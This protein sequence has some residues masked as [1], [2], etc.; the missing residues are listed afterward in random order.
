M[1]M[2]IRCIPHVHVVV[3]ETEYN[4]AQRCSALGLVR[5]SRFVSSARWSGV[6]TS[7]TVTIDYVT[8]YMY[9]YCARLNYN[10]EC[11]HNM[12]WRVESLG[13]GRVH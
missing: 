1:L 3:D 8:M 13:D 4:S 6:F 7:V 2:G 11:K 12:L 5:V 10:S 9:V